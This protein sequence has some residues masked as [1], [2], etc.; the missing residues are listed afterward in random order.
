[1]PRGF[2]RGTGDV[3]QAMGAMDDERTPD[4]PKNRD[5]PSTQT[6]P[7][8]MPNPMTNNRVLNTRTV[9]DSG[10]HKPA[11]RESNTPAGPNRAP[12]WRGNIG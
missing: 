8:Q 4:P 11:S 10:R 1:V 2:N 3:G 9:A 12:R 6:A 5:V 7:A